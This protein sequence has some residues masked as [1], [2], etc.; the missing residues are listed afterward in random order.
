MFWFTCTTFL[1]NNPHVGLLFTVFPLFQTTVTTQTFANLD[2][3][4][5]SFVEI[6]GSYP[7]R[8]VKNVQQTDGTLLLAIDSTTPGERLTR[9]V[10]TE[11]KKPLMQVQLSWTKGSIAM[12]TTP[13]ECAKWVEEHN[14]R[15]L[16]VAGNSLYRYF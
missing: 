7:E 2:R 14:I 6:K 11:H 12:S 10:C 8:T 4:M 15:Q 3:Q 16:N 9:R 13:E 5:L 1:H